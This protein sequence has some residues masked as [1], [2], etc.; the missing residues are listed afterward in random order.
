MTRR[1]TGGAWLFWFGV[2]LVVGGMMLAVRAQLD[3]AHVAL[4]FLLVVLGASSAAGRTLGVAVAGVAFLGFNFF[5]LPPYDTLVIANPLDWLVLLAFLVTGVVAAQLLE[6][7]RN[8]AESARRRAEEIDRLATLGAET[9]NAA[10]AEEA[11]DAIA[12]VI[13]QAMAADACEIFLREEGDTLRLAGRSPASTTA[14]TQ[15]GLLL[16]LVHHAEATA[17]RAD[18]TLSLVAGALDVTQHDVAA[19][20]ELRALGIPLSVRGHI[21]GALRLSANTPFTLS[22]DQRRVL[23]AL[24]YY[25]AL[26]TERVRLAN[27]EEEAE[28]LRRADRL[29]D[30]LLASVSHDLRTPLTAIKGIAHEIWHGGD[31]E[32]AYTIEQ[33]ADRLSAL[34]SDLLE[35]SQLNAGSLRVV[36]LLNT[37]DEVVGA[38]LDRVE[39]AHGTGRIQA[40]I[41]NEH[42]ILVGTF[43]FAH[44][45]RALTN[46]LENAVKY[47]PA[48]APV[49][50]RAWREGGRLRFAVDDTGPGV[51]PGDEEKIFEPFYRGVR[52]PD[53][54]RGTGLGL[55]IARQL[56]EAQQGSLRYERRDGGGSRFVL[57]LPAGAAPAD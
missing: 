38:A 31:P 30:A 2:L 11:L 57:D 48:N 42:G 19:L 35:L 8:E 36:A 34:V 46:L 22:S 26:G 45:M 51:A 13:R 17:E 21:V 55:S 18:G 4:A 49:T 24:S 29:K 16:Y 43:D 47:S 44:T 27:A 9:L 20:A 37:A 53:G 5:F 40:H 54:V 15:S 41:A 39:A 6:G 52:V 50:L 28:S 3:K 56:A 32:R 14:T 23:S 12:T 1:Q 7:Q 25:A 10:R 33:E